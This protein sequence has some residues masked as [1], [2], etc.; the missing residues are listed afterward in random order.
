M[1]HKCVQ[2][3]M[4]VHICS[5]RRN[6]PLSLSTLFLRPGPS[7]DPWLTSTHTLHGPPSDA[8]L[9]ARGSYC[10]TWLSTQAL[11]ITLRSSCLQGKHFQL[12]HLPTSNSSFQDQRQNSETF[13]KYTCTSKSLASSQPLLLESLT[14]QHSLTILICTRT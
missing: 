13:V 10:C 12:G 11:K 5:I 4:S 8:S 2:L 9:S 1:L 14:V 7:M 3:N 6:L